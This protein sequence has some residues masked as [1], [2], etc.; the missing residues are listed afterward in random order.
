MTPI[1]ATSH[2]D[3]LK[4]I[5]ISS[6]RS[7][8]A[9]VDSPRRRRPAKRM[10]QELRKVG[11]VL[12]LTRDKRPLSPD[13]QISDFKRTKLAT[14]IMPNIASIVDS[15][16]DG[17][18]TVRVQLSSARSGVS[19]AAKLTTT[20]LSASTHQTRSTATRGRSSGALNSTSSQSTVMGAKSSTP[21]SRTGL[22][23]SSTMSTVAIIAENPS[24]G[25][26][27]ST[28][29]ATAASTA[30]VSAPR[31]NADVAKSRTGIVKTTS[32]KP[33]LRRVQSTYHTGS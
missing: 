31:S 29:T 27:S 32:K 21:A 9:L 12:R 19:H 16:L 18:D 28:S 10:S 22:S 7:S 15:T 11:R 6:S 24:F 3:E 4:V 5:E 13:N 14:T 30:A 25:A 2:I 20:R 8:D 23:Q 17:D 26:G 1:S 33:A